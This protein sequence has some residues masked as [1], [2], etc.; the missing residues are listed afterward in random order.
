MSTPTT[1]DIPGTV[2]NV[3]PA[4]VLKTPDP[5]LTTEAFVALCAT[6][7]PFILV[8]FH[9]NM[10]GPTKAAILSALGAIYGAFILWHGS[11]VRAARAIGQGLKAG[12][13]TVSIKP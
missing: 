13:N 2:L 9:Y 7:L 11:R 10:S 3:D 1:P 4:V 6:G 12:G 5:A 8:T